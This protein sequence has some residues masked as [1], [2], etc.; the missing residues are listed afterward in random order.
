M[1]G[2]GAFITPMVNL[3]VCMLVVQAF[4]RIGGDILIKDVLTL[5]IPYYTFFL[6]FTTAKNLNSIAHKPSSDRT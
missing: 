6:Q 3:S 2:V 4:F 1:K 5:V